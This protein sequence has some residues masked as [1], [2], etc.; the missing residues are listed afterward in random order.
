MTNKELSQT[1]RNELKNSGYNSK[2]ISI[3]V[4]ACGYSTSLH[5][6]IKNPYINRKEIESL[7]KHYEDF[8]RDER[9]YEIL[10]GGNTY[11]FVDYEYGVFELPAEEWKATAE[12][13]LKDKSE[14]VN[15]FDGLF[16][17]NDGSR[18][19]IR[20]QNTNEHISFKCSSLNEL[21][22]FLFKFA[23]FGSIAA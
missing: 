4:K 1:I 8:E 9:T 23:T 11:L 18:S 16:F 3:K 2:D 14:I 17:I 7:L 15:I 20:Q 21:S 12:G 6:K 22:V 5:I 13:I 19:E 10:E